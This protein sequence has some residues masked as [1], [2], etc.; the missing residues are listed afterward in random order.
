MQGPSEGEILKGVGA[1][2]ARP[3]VGPLD[4]KGK[5]KVAIVEN[6]PSF[7]SFA[8]LRNSLGPSLTQLK[9]FGV[10]TSGPS[11]LLRDRHGPFE[12]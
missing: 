8:P 7:G 10:Q 11:V 12:S 1:G 2:G 4:S 6:R 9:A 5:E 3:V